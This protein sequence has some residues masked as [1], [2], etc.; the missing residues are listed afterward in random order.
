[1]SRSAEG[2]PSALDAWGGGAEAS[3]LVLGGAAFAGRRIVERRPDRRE[4]KRRK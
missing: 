1:V 2:A 4:R 3:G